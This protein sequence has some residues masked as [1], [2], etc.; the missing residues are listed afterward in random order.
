MSEML[1][2]INHMTNTVK[3]QKSNG[4]TVDEVKKAT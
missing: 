3:C 2:T 1:K 4:L